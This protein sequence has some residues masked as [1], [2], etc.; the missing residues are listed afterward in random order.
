[1]SRS[2]DRSQVPLTDEGSGNLFLADDGTYK[3]IDVGTPHLDAGEYITGTIDGDITQRILGVNAEGNT[4]YLGAIDNMNVTPVIARGQWNIEGTFAVEGTDIISEIDSKENSLGLGTA[5]QILAT[6]SSGD[7]KEWIYPPEGGGI[8]ELAKGQ[9]IKAEDPTGTM[10]NILGPGIDG[11]SYENKLLIGAIAFEEIALR[12]PVKIE[13]RLGIKGN[14]NIFKDSTSHIYF[15]NIDETVL[16]IIV[17]DYNTGNMD[18]IINDLS[19]AD[20]GSISLIPGGNIEVSAA[21]PTEANQLTRKDYVDGVISKLLAK[22]AE[23][24]IAIDESE[25]FD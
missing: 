19:G 20:A 1:M 5:G 22:L 8:P 10:Q 2:L 6:N 25:I 4:I 12:A 23:N 18:F 11:G 15:K 24:G 3:A 7:G 14:F 17:R 13:S 16:G 9:Y 21:A